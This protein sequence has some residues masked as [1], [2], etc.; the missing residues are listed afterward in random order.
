MTYTVLK[1]APACARLRA[2]FKL[3]PREKITARI[4]TAGDGAIGRDG[5]LA[6]TNATLGLSMRS[7]ETRCA[8]GAGSVAEVDGLAGTCAHQAI[9][10]PR[11]TPATR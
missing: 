10:L 9:P 11:S 6:R 1:N 2:W 3:E 4:T 8:R 7:V 5:G